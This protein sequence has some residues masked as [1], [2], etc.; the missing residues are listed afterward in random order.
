MEAEQENISGQEI[1]QINLVFN[2]LYTKLNRKV[3]SFEARIGEI[4]DS[5]N[6]RKQA[7]IRRHQKRVS[8][9]NE[10]ENNNNMTDIINDLKIN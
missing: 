5:L 6:K 7:R 3:A 8:E 2:D 4:R 1:E 9:N 10:E